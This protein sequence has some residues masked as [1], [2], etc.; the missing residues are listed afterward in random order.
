MPTP[1]KRRAIGKTLS[2]RLVVN[3]QSLQMMLRSGVVRRADSMPPLPI[4][5]TRI[6]IAD[7]QQRPVRKE[8]VSEQGWLSRIILGRRAQP[9]VMKRS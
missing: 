2:K 4:R 5:T 3:V 8:S 1:M 7:G 6:Q 9:V